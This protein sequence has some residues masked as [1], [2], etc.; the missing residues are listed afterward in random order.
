MAATGGGDR[1]RGGASA[2]FGPLLAAEGDQGDFRLGFRRP[3]V[4][5][6]ITPPWRSACGLR[7]TFEPLAS[8]RKDPGSRPW[9]CSCL[10]PTRST[11]L[12]ITVRWGSRARAGLLVGGAA[13]R[14]VASTA[15]RRHKGRGGA[16]RLDVAAARK[17]RAT[18]ERLPLPA[19]LADLP[20]R[21]AARFGSM[22]IASRIEQKLPQ[23]P[24]AAPWSRGICRPGCRRRCRPGCPGLFGSEVSSD[25]RQGCFELSF[26]AVFWGRCGGSGGLLWR[27]LSAWAAAGGSSGCSWIR[28]AAAAGARRDHQRTAN[29]QV[30]SAS[31]R[32][33][34]HRA[35]MGPA[36]T[37]RA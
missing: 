15:M 19:A 33:A 36:A 23:A 35:R 27:L 21:T 12:T 25:C 26:G 7:A 34:A 22:A 18:T 32:S 11:L 13:A 14:S 31:T 37:A 1:A 10:A 3:R 6:R 16:I 30:R 8:T 2:T 4:S 29:L 17:S 20:Q 28:A 9:R 5:R 24:G